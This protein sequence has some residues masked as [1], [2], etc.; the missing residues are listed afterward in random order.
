MVCV[1]FVLLIYVVVQIVEYVLSPGLWFWL[2]RDDCQF[3]FLV[4]TVIHCCGYLIIYIEDFNFYP[5]MLIQ[6]MKMYQKFNFR[7]QTNKIIFYVLPSFIISVQ[8]L[9]VAALDDRLLLVSFFSDSVYNFSF[10]FPF[11]LLYVSIIKHRLLF[12][13]IYIT[14]VQLIYNK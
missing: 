4:L 5:I 1:C 13:N 2:F 7:K 10:G 12:V 9:D 6:Y 14:Y 8:T 3:Q 11:C